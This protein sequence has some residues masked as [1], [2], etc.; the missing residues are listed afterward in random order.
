MWYD[1]ETAESA[2]FLLV[3][4]SMHVG[5]RYVSFPSL[6]TVEYY[7]EGFEISVCSFVFEVFWQA[8]SICTL[9]K[10]GDQNLQTYI[11]AD[12]ILHS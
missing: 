5:K 12:G 11:Q 6:S 3:T 2:N 1:A 7:S 4:I 9:H 8:D 10:E